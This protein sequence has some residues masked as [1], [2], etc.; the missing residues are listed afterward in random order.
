MP[1]NFVCQVRLN[2]TQF[3][4]LHWDGKLTADRLGSKYEALSDVIS[5]APQYVSRKLP[6]V[7]KLNRATGKSQVEA[8]FDMVEMWNVESAIKSLVFDTTASNSGWKSG[9][10]RLLEDLFQKKL[11]YCACRHHI[12]QLVVS[13]A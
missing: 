3:A 11:F 1:S 7:Q 8:T 13:V 5:G 6:G 4:A 10:A 2:P 9:A 12:Y